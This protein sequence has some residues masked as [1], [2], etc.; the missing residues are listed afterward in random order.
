MAFKQDITTVLPAL[1]DVAGAMGQSL[2]VA[3]RAFNDALMGRF[4]MLKNDLGISK[5]ALVQFGLEMN[6]ARPRHQPEVFTKAFLALANCGRVQGR[7]GQ[8]RADLDRASC[9]A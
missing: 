9:P 4:A 1:E 3:A 8:A 7:G 2:P 6:K 5:E